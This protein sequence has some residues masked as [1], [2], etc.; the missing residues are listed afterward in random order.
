[1]NHGYGIFDPNKDDEID[2]GRFCHSNGVENSILAKIDR[3]RKR[4]REKNNPSAQQQK[5]HRANLQQIKGCN[6]EA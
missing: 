5:R 6:Y 3:D 1:M 2:R 4:E